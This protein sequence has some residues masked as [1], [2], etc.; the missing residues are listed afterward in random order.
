MQV[1]AATLLDD[2]R[3]HEF[4]RTKI[5]EVTDVLNSG[6]QGLRPLLEA[7]E[8]TLAM[9]SALTQ[10]GLPLAARFARA[11]ACELD[12]SGGV[13]RKTLHQLKAQVLAGL[14][15]A[16]RGR[17]PRWRA[18]RPRRW[19]A[20]RGS[21]QPPQGQQPRTQSQQVKIVGRGYE[22]AVTG[23][24]AQVGQRQRSKEPCGVGARSP[25]MVGIGSQPFVHGPQAVS[26]ISQRE[27]QRENWAGPGKHITSTKRLAIRRFT[28]S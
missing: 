15:G 9:L 24:S 23:G 27:F 10:G 22:G 1:A 11:R 17:S 18:A 6:A 2:Q 4:W 26:P 7:Y 3:L 13:K 25:L 19:A 16:R 21:R 8:P 14:H 5:D 20:R 28:A 12:A